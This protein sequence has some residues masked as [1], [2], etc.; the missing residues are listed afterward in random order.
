MRI[1]TWLCF[2]ICSVSPFLEFSRDPRNYIWPHGWCVP[3]YNDFLEGSKTGI[4]GNEVC[5]FIKLLFWPNCFSEQPWGLTYWC[6]LPWCPPSWCHSTN[7]TDHIVLFW[8]RLMNAWCTGPTTNW[9]Q[10]ND[11]FCASE[12]KTTYWSKHLLL[13][14]L[15][16]WAGLSGVPMTGIWSTNPSPESQR[17]QIHWPFSDWSL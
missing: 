14:G 10:Q 16:Q 15:E 17:S 5:P 4:L 11:S 12:F 7:M 8:G 2:K 9:H 6:C 3:V 13:Q 1:K